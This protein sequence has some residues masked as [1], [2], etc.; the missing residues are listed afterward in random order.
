MGLNIYLIKNF[1]FLLL[2]S[3]SNTS[4]LG[5]KI[6][7]VILAFWL[8]KETGDASTFGIISAANLFSVVFFNFISGAI[9]DRYNKK[10]YYYYQI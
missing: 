7:E 4:K 10:G 1:N 6:Y 9:V 2:L 8:V 5:T 3:S